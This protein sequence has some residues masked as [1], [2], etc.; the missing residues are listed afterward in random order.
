M[1][2]GGSDVF[3]G[4]LL[5]LGDNTVQRPALT[6]ISVIISIHLQIIPL[7]WNVE[8]PSRLLRLAQR[9]RDLLVRCVEGD[10]AHAVL[11]LLR[12]HAQVVDVEDGR[13]LGQRQ[14]DVLAAVNLE[15]VEASF[16]VGNLRLESNS[17]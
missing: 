6:C 7:C 16:L 9:R 12:V 15:V 2:G 8:P 17:K 1:E 13:A 5:R 4:R 11:V 3:N 14:D 10:V